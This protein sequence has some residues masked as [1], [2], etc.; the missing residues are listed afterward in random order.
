MAFVSLSDLK[1]HL[2]QHKTVTLKT[3]AT[4]FASDTQLLQLKLQFFVQ[5]GQVKETL[6]T[7]NCQSHCTL[8]PTDA[9]YTYHWQEN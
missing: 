1:K 8:C 3:L 2:K 9:I 7:P 5:Q 4:H 6:K